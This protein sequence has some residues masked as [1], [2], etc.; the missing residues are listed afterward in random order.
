MLPPDLQLADVT[1]VYKNK[2]KN[3]KDNYRRVSKRL[4]RTLLDKW[5]KSVDNGGALGAL[6][7]DLSKAFDC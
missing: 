3:F 2:S 4:L 7:T 1:L 5:K 6:F